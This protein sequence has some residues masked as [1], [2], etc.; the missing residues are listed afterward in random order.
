MNLTITML[1]FPAP[2]FVSVAPADHLD[3][4]SVKQLSQQPFLPGVL[5]EHTPLYL[6]YCPPLQTTWTRAA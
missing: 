3:K 4:G 5:V 2:L 1:P 6:H